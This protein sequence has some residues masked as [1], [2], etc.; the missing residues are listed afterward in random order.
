MAPKRSR[1]ITRTPP[2]QKQQVETKSL[3]AQR[4]K[5]Q[6]IDPSAELQNE[7]P[8]STVPP[9]PNELVTQILS[10]LLQDDFEKVKNDLRPPLDPL[11][12]P[13]FFRGF[14]GSESA[15]KLYI[16]RISELGIQ[17]KLFAHY[18]ATFIIPDNLATPATVEKVFRYRLREYESLKQTTGRLLSLFLLKFWGDDLV[19]QMTKLRLLVEDL[20]EVQSLLRIITGCAS[21]ECASYN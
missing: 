17:C 1:H 9:L 8:A 21:K 18:I 5:Y 10:L 6:A 13:P 16:S 19:R 20:K 4:Q 11:Q 12:S 15:P 3:R 7:S 14:P 2:L